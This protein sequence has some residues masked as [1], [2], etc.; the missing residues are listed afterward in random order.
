LPHDSVSDAQIE[1]RQMRGAAGLPP[2]RAVGLFDDHVRIRAAHG[3]RGDTGV[4][5]LPDPATVD[6]GSVS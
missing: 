6:H 5:C 4:R 1:H 2:F 3:D